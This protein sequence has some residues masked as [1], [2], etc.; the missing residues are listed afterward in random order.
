LARR[1]GRPAREAVRKGIEGELRRISDMVREEDRVIAEQVHRGAREMSG[2]PML[3]VVEGR[4]S[5]FQA[6]YMRWMGEGP[7]KG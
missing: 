5:H 6:A 3:G 2:P 4:L 1:D 7:G